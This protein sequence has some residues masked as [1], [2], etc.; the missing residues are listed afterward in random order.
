MAGDSSTAGLTRTNLMLAFRAF[1]GTSPVHLPGIR[2]NMNGNKDAYLLEGSDLSIYDSA[3]QKWVVQGEHHR[4][5]G[6]DAEL[7]VEHDRQRLHLTFVARDRP[8]PRRLVSP[9]SRSPRW[10]RQV[11][12]GGPPDAAGPSRATEP[13]SSAT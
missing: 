3:Q 12:G 10:S 11:G 9:R 13:I 4:A 5:V 2:I 8:T 6:Q 7:H 1:D